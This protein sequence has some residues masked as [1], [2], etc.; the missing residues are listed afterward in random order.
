[1]CRAQLWCMNLFTPW[2]PSRPQSPDTSGPHPFWSLGHSNGLP[3]DFMPSRRSSIPSGISEHPALRELTLNHRPRRGPLALHPHTFP[4]PSTR[5]P[6]IEPSL[7]GLMRHHAASWATGDTRQKLA[8]QVDQVS[9]RL[10][11]HSESTISTISADTV[12]IHLCVMS[13][14]ANNTYSQL[15]V[16]H[17]TLL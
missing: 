7:S 8:I 1:M 4:S 13:D 12:S 9:E 15:F 14:R 16:F 3:G 10:T 6:G 11:Q 5:P 17:M 2:R